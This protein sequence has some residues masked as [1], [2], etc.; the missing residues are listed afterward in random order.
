MVSALLHM[1]CVV[2]ASCP[3]E[4]GIDAVRLPE[5]RVTA[6]FPIPAVAEHERSRNGPAP[7]VAMPTTVHPE[8][9]HAMKHPPAIRA[10]I[11]GAVD[12]DRVVVEFGV[13][14]DVVGG[15]DDRRRAEV[16]R[17]ADA[18]GRRCRNHDCR[19]GE[20]RGCER[21]FRND[22]HLTRSCCW[23]VMATTDVARCPVYTGMIT[24]SERAFVCVS[25]L[26]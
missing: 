26:Y 1:L 9:A 15:H 17:D 10:V 24:S 11:P 25:S 6:P 12:V 2:H 18:C 13:V 14:R 3:D 4:A 20:Q 16:H 22:L 8:H 5:T 19:A 21:R 23:N 7:F